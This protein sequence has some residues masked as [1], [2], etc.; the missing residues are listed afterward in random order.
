MGV[1]Q[2]KGYS[3]ILSVCAEGQTTLASSR[4][5]VYQRS[6]MAGKGDHEMIGDEKPEGRNDMRLP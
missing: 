4:V 3:N 1:S 5:F 6:E 2:Y